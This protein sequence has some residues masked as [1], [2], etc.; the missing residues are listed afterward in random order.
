MS[1]GKYKRRRQ[2]A[3]QNAQQQTTKPR[4]PDGE[5]IVAKREAKPTEAR[6]Y[7]AHSEKESF[8]ELR[9]IIKKSSFTDWCLMVFTGMLV[10]VS[11]CQIHISGKQVDLTQ[12]EQRAWISISPDETESAKAVTTGPLFTT[13]KIA[14]IGKTPATD[15]DSHFYVE[16]VANGN[17]PHFEEEGKS[18]VPGYDTFSKVIMPDFPQPV[19]IGRARIV[20]GARIEDVITDTEK[21]LLDTGAGYVAT[22]GILYYTDSFQIRHWVKYCS[23]RPYAKGR[24]IAGACTAYNSIDND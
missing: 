4:L 23:W 14:N 15:I 13:L 8:M 18:S 21:T 22:H 1:K 17:D 12:K 24:F 6:D 20:D 9:E 7:V 2:S 10:V 3:H 16:V 11:S 5:L 19:R